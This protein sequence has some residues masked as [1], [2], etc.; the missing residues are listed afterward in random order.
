[1]PWGHSKTT[2]K[3]RRPSSAA[4]TPPVSVGCTS[5]TA[6]RASGYGSNFR[7]TEF[8]S[9]IGRIQLQRLPEWTAARTRN[10]LLLAEALGDLPAVRVP[11][12]PECIEHAWYK[13][14]G[15]VKPV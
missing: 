6:S 14:Y 2:A 1:M 7:L 11:L 3:P 8:Q 10:A 13:F 15:F 12:P 9:A 5:G 4:S